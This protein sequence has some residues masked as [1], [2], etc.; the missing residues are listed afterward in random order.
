MTMLVVGHL[1][2]HIVVNILFQEQSNISY[3]NQICSKQSGF[4]KKLYFLPGYDFLS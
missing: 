4:K 3:A 2:I 1:L